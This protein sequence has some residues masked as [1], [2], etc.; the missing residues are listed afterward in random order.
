MVQY[1][2]QKMCSAQ[3]SKERGERERN[4]PLEICNGIEKKK[5]TQNLKL[6]ILNHEYEIMKNWLIQADE[7]DYSETLI[8]LERYELLFHILNPFE[9][10]Y[11]VFIV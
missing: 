3:R 5:E 10:V 2:W 6:F 4:K 1:E 8:D 11:V 7:P 9:E